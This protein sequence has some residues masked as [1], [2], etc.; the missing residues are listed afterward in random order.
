[1]YHYKETM[2]KLIGQEVESGRVKGAGRNRPVGS[3]VKI[4]ALLCRPEDMG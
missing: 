1:M 4:S 3:R 2:D